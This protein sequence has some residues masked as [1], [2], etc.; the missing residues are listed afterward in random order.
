MA[1]HVKNPQAIRI[2]FSEVKSART[3]P[4]CLAGG[5]MALLSLM[6][7]IGVVPI[8][9]G[10]SDSWKDVPAGLLC[11][12]IVAAIWTW[13]KARQRREVA[14]ARSSR[15][16]ELISVVDQAF[17]H[18]EVNT[19]NVSEALVQIE[20]N[21]TA[22]QASLSVVRPI[23]FVQTA[24]DTLGQFHKID[25]AVRMNA[26]GQEL[27]ER[28]AKEWGMVTD[29]L[30]GPIVIPDRFRGALAEAGRLIAD[31]KNHLSIAPVWMQAQVGEAMKK[32][33]EAMKQGLVA[34]QT[35]MSNLASQVQDS[36]FRADQKLD[37]IRDV[38]RR[39]ESELQ[40]RLW[41]RA[42]GRRA[43]GVRRYGVAP[44]HPD[45]PWNPFHRPGQ[46]SHQLSR[47]IPAD[48]RLG[49]ARYQR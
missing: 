47:P 40:F 16:R 19:D 48:Q 36:A 6:G 30:P 5:A 23:D 27:A 28:T 29:P 20:A 2:P 18:H 32:E 11:L 34:Q 12:G 35:A 13:H 9:I 37:Q 22:L 38:T 21:N 24:K 3:G 46:E 26:L 8:F 44:I 4:G 7:V 49:C 1:S 31:G 10:D 41:P 45:T 14:D 39:L 17:Y 43:A 33:F 25:L 42:P 15:R